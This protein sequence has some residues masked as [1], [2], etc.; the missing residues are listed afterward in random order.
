[1]DNYISGSYVQ[2]SYLLG[3]K[4]SSYLTG[5]KQCFY[6]YTNLWLVDVISILGWYNLAGPGFNF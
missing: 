4:W 5:H 3:D 1:M 2:D 6:T